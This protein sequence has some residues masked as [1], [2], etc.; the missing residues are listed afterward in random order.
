MGRSSGPRSPPASAARSSSSAATTPMIVAPSADLDLALRAIV[1]AAV[2]TAGQRCT[3]LRRLIVHRSIRADAHAPAR[4][5]PTPACRSAT[6]AR[7]GTLV[8][9]LIDARRAATRCRAALERRAGR[10]RR[11]PRRRAVAEGAPNGGS[12]VAPA[13]VEMPAQTDV[14]LRGDLRADPL[15][16]GLSTTST[17]RSRSTT[18]CRRACR[19]SIFTIDLREA[20]RSSRRPAPTAASPTSTSAHRAPRSAAPSAARRRPAAAARPAPTPGRPTC[21]APPTRSTIGATLPLAQGVRF[22]F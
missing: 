11:G 1:F 12:Y 21:A 14:V 17:R 8:G 5:R 18:T 7:P 4:R 20:E 15:R 3:T 13:L 2:G 19:S 22:D 10:G 6:R 16:D 9:P